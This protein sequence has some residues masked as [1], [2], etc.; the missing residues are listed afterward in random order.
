MSKKNRPT[1][2]EALAEAYAIIDHAPLRERLGVDID[3]GLLARALTHRSFAN[4]HGGLPNNE[5][6]EFLGDAVLGLTV[7]AELLERHPDATESTISKMRASVVSGYACADIGRRIE[8]GQHLLLGRG[9]LASGGRDKESI[10]ADTVEALLG[11][12]YRQHGFATTRRVILDLF[13]PLIDQAT[14]KSRREDWKTV[15]QEHAAAHGKDLPAYDT[16]ATGPAHDQTF[17]AVVRLGEEELGRGEGH[18]KKLAEQ[19]AAREG[20]RALGAGA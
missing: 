8:L 16:T 4:E 5:R 13:A 18:N 12:V 10:L 19:A 11:A 17:T 1:G 2:E 3:D 20:C 9:E 14:S 15:L 7:A 6:L